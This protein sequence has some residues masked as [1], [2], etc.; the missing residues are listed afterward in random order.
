[1][2]SIAKLAMILTVNSAQ[3]SS[4]LSAAAEKLKSFA[5]S[6][7]MIGG[8]FAAIPTTGAGFLDFLKRGMEQVLDLKK[9]ADRFGLS[10]RSAATFQLMA[11][12]SAEAMDKSLA[13][14]ARGLGSV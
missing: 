8:A 10:M 9:M 7:P 1:M 13:F 5:S 11:G 12:G 14:L 3:F 6:V 4:G 2:A